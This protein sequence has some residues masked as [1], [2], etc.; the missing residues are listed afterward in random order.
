VTN[1]NPA[2]LL[3]LQLSTEAA[4]V[5]CG[6]LDVQVSLELDSTGNAQVTGSEPRSE[7]AERFVA[8]EYLDLVTERA[9]TE[10]RD[11][12]RAWLRSGEVA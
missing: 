12:E 6:P 2:E 10:S 9:L 7:A 11:A 8:A 5:S 1:T 3:L 4:L